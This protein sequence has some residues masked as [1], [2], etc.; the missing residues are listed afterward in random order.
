[1]K[2]QKLF[3]VLALVSLL[4]ISCSTMSNCIAP[5]TKGLSFDEAVKV[6][7][8]PEKINAWMLR[9]LRWHLGKRWHAPRELYEEKLGNCI[10]WANFAAYLLDRNG[11]EAEVVFGFYSDPPSKIWWSDHAVGVYKKDGK[12]FVVGDSRGRMGGSAD[13]NISAGSF[14]NLEK[15]AE[16]AVSPY[17]LSHY[18]VGGQFL[19]FAPKGCKN[20]Y[21]DVKLNW[22]K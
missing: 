13:F 8:T 5:N 10:C 7:N 22:P 1:M 15:V 6:L 14:K 19:T 21:E 20:R 4:V 12:W 17:E 3:L 16:Y 11:Y 18:E 2:N 9:N